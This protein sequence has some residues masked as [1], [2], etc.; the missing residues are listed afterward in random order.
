MNTAQASAKF[1]T[2]VGEGQAEVY[3]VI[4]LYNTKDYL[5]HCLDSLLAQSH[6][7][8]QIFLVDDGSTDGSSDLAK[9]YAARHPSIRY[10]QQ[11]NQGQSQARNRGLDALKTFLEAQQLA[12]KEGGC[13][14]SAP[15]NSGRA[16][17]SFVD[18]DDWLSE[19]FYERLLSQAEQEEAEVVVAS[20]WDHAP[21]SLVK[22]RFEEGQE[23]L[24]ITPS[25]ANK[26]FRYELVKDERFLPGLW[27]EDLAFFHRLLLSQKPRVCF[28]PEA[29]YHCHC[30]PLSTMKNENAQKNLDILQVFDSLLPLVKQGA[31]EERQAYERVLVEHLLI[32]SI[33]RLQTMRSPQKREV[34]KQIR[35]YVKVKAPRWRQSPAVKSLPFARR[36]VAELNA[37]GFASLSQMLLKGKSVLAQLH[38][39]ARV[40]LR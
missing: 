32:T 34:I 40:R 15:I 2:Q 37:R 30:R 26:L 39:K 8:R 23:P 27:Y 3:V 13:D 17:V 20:M 10:L 16:Y 7:P 36:L 11:E 1:H 4:A 24:L 33:N 25:V 35:A 31:E 19:D 5:A 28:A 14:E 38:K 12:S 21:D 6:P 29:V 18:S 22:H 9:D